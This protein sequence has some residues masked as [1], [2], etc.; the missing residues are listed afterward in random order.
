MTVE[1]IKLAAATFACGAVVVAGAVV[2]VMGPG[3]APDVV[4]GG[5]GDSATNTSYVQPTAS[6]MKLPATVVDTPATTNDMAPTTLAT[7]MAAPT[8]KATA[9]P[10]CVNNGQCP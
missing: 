2:S 3:A 7:P 8:Y 9:A 10:G 1:R 6:A 5:S 4:A